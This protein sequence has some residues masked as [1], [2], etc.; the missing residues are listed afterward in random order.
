[1]I[2]KSANESHI[3]LMSLHA[4]K[5]KLK[6]IAQR[7]KA[8]LELI[9]KHKAAGAVADGHELDGEHFVEHPNDVTDIAVRE[10]G[11]HDWLSSIAT[12]V[13][14]G[15]EAKEFAEA[16]KQTKLFARL[17]ATLKSRGLI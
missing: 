1:M 10:E 14:V 9:D 11:I 5:A 3:R 15:K 7:V 4:D 2:L 12:A 16:V 8:V 6:G 17:V 13:Q